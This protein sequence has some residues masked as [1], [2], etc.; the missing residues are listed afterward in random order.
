[1]HDR[2]KIFNRKWWAFAKMGCGRNFFL[3]LELVNLIAVPSDVTL[4]LRPGGQDK[5]VSACRGR[6]L[7]YTYMY[8]S[9][10]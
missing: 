1:M 2:T 10:S 4:G 8:T 5:G 6:L 3:E 7:L 9:T